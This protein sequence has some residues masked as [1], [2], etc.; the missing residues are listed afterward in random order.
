M[1][2]PPS[3]EETMRI[4]LSAHRLLA[5]RLDRLFEAAGAPTPHESWLLTRLYRS[6]GRRT[7]MQEVADQLS[8]SRSGVSRLIDRMVRS[9]YV[10]REES[11]S[12]RRVTYIVLTDQGRGALRYAGDVY[13][14]AFADTFLRALTPEELVHLLEL[15]E[16][17]AE[18]W[19][20]PDLT[21]ARE[22]AGTAGL[23]G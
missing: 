3:P 6:K 5:T 11:T 13:R 16:R 22:T 12:D 7:G 20:E 17:L 18:S 2:E 21:P 23:P 4:F 8:L 19:L 15:L 1:P 14:S 9:G 10:R